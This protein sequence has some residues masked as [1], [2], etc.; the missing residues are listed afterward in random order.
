MKSQ[1]GE[2]NENEQCDGQHSKLTHLITGL[3]IG[4]FL[5]I[6]LAP[7]SGDDTR[8][9]IASKC[10]AGMDSVNTS[11]GKTSRQVGRLINRGQQHVGEAVEAGREAFKKAK[12]AAH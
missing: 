5:A 1:A 6:V 8:E 10:K 2:H 3:G 12:A 4:A 9:W 11:V 7:Q